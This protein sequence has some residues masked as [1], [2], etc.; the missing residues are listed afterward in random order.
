MNKEEQE[1]FENLLE[2]D[3]YRLDD[4]TAAQPR[5]VWHYSKLMAQALLKLDEAKANVKVV[6]AEVDSVV[7]ATP[8]KFGLTKPTEMSVKKA[9]Y[10]STKMIS[11]MKKLHRAQYRVN[12][13]DGA[14]KALDHRRTSLTILNSQDERGYYSKPTE[15]SRDKKMSK[16]RKVLK[17]KR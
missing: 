15:P 14:N 2:I 10:R 4:E 9:I 16:H 17:R 11:A 7:R 5:K 13:L 12:L 6:E 8:K 1:E 3:R